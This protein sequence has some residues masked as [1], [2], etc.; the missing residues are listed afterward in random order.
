MPVL[1]VVMNVTNKSGCSALV[2]TIALTDDNQNKNNF[3][4]S[5]TGPTLALL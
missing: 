4:G 5:A 3:T 2:L 1:A